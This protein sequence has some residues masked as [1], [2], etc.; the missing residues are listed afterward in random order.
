MPAVV[1]A[2]TGFE[3]VTELAS[4]TVPL[5]LEPPR[6]STSTPGADLGDGEPVDPKIF[7]ASLTVELRTLGRVP[8]SRFEGADRVRLG[9]V[10][11]KVLVDELA[12]G[13]QLAPA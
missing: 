11:A 13:R 12:E 7:P 4:R 3:L 5:P 2:Q 6:R 8:E 10:L 1:N 9:G